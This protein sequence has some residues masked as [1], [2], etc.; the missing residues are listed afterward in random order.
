[1]SEPKAIPSKEEIDELAMLYLDA[2]ANVAKAKE[3]SDVFYDQL[4][5]MIE[6]H[7]YVPKRAHKSRRIEGLVYKITRSASQSVDVD[8]TAVLRLK[9]ALD[10]WGFQR[11]FRKL[12]KREPVFVIQDDAQALVAT[13]LLKGAPADLQKLFSESVVIKGNSPSL[14]VE[15]KED[16]EAKSK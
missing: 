10:Q 15:N 14:K 3:T 12:F 11:Y 1:M 16:K 8:G 5:K 2:E 13:L 4:V 7:G 9:A 6:E